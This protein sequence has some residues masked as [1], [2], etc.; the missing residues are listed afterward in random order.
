MES[1]AA[2]KP[3]FVYFERFFQLPKSRFFQK[4][5]HSGGALFRL[6]RSKRSG[7]ARACSHEAAVPVAQALREE[8][9][10]GRPRALWE[11]LVKPTQVSIYR[12]GKQGRTSCSHAGI[13]TISVRHVPVN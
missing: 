12:L 13:R 6:T 4:Q 8:R 7:E 10:H 5:K 11:E 1:A 9:P 2:D 3:R